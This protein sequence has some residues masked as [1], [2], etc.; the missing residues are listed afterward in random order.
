MTPEMI[1]THEEIIK[2]APLVILD[3]N[4]S[5]EA[6]EKVLEMCCVHHVPVFFEP[7]DPAKSVKAFKSPW[8][9]A[10]KYASP[11]IHELRFIAN[12]DKKGQN[13]PNNEHNLEDV[14]NECTE[15]AK[16]IKAKT[17]ISTLLVTIGEHGVLVFEGQNQVQHF[18]THQAPEENVVSV[19]G[20]GDCLAAGFISGLLKGHDTTTS[21]EFGLRAASLSLK[22]TFTVPNEL[23]MQMIQK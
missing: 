4:F 7:T 21:V 18:K 16:Q 1:M 15:L 14:V 22:N 2:K 8:Q 17:S 13:D 19:S 12:S 3:A 6:M 23:S 10:I 11:N 20:A 5:Q 9:K